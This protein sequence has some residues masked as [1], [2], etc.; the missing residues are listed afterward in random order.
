M[1]IPRLTID[2]SG[3]DPRDSCCR[4]KAD[5]QIRL[6]SGYAL[7]AITRIALQTIYVA[8]VSSKASTFG[9][10]SINDEYGSTA[11]AERHQVVAFYT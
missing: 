8:V 1:L 2:L 10:N 7:R 9:C 11:L 4:V 5:L 6:S 3:H